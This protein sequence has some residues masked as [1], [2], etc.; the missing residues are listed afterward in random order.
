MM[1][2]NFLKDFA[3]KKIVKRN[4]SLAQP[5]DTKVETVGIIFDESVFK[6]KDA[7]IDALVA[8]GVSEDYIRIMVFRDRVKK[9]ESFNYPVFSHADMTW[10]G[11][12][13]KYEVESFTKVKFDLLINYFDREK[14]PLLAV[15]QKSAARF[16]VGFASVDK[17]LNHFMIDTV[18]EEHKVFTDELIRYLRILNKL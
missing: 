8:S 7:V 2:L 11:D 18:V 14:T 17:R 13:K 4:L 6:D 10:S 12:V 9:S 1:F 3:T 16:K 15:A 5:D